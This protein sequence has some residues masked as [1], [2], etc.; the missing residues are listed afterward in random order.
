MRKEA[1]NLGRLNPNCFYL[2]NFK[3]GGVIFEQVLSLSVLLKVLL[4]IIRL[5]LRC[6]VRDELVLEVCFKLIVLNKTILLRQSVLFYIVAKAI[7]SIFS[8]QAAVAL[9]FSIDEKGSK[10]SRSLRIDFSTSLLIV[11]KFLIPE[12]FVEDNRVFDS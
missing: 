12:G 9:P 1:K 3:C 10:E 6:P 5:P 2:K 8:A 4:R 11:P 7:S